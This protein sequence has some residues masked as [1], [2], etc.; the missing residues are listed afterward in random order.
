LEPDFLICYKGKW[1]ILEINGEDFHSGIVKTTKDHERARRFKH[2]GLLFIEAYDYTKCR[3]D[4]VGVVDEFLK[5]LAN[6]K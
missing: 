3:S 5:L 4:P 2:Y 6:H 1:G